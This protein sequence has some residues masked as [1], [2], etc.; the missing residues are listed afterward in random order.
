[1]DHLAIWETLEQMIINFRRKGVPIP[2]DLMSQLRSAKTL[3]NILKADPSHQDTRQ[4]VDEHLLGIE[5]YLFSKG[6]EQFGR[7]YVEEWLQKLGEASEKISEE[8]ESKTR[9]VL[10]VPRDQKWVRVRPS[11][12]LPIEELKVLV[13]ELELSYN[14]QPD[15][16]LLVYGEKED[17]KKL[18]QEMTTKYGSKIA[19]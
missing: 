13:G 18:I 12:D 3:I 7:E 4:K 14:I 1:M 17:I 19:R 10:G 9:F 8:G 5:S 2:A 11:E 6:Q 15:G 16:C